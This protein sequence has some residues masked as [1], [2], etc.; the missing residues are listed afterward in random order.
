MKTLYSILYITINTALDEKVSIGIL[1]S[2]GDKFI[3]KYSSEKLLAIKGLMDNDRYN[4]IKQYL[5]SL[6]EE[7]NSE[8]NHKDKNGIEFPFEGNKKYSEGYINYLANYSNNIIQFSPAKSINIV[9]GTD[10]Y[11]KL[12]ERYIFSYP[13]EIYQPTDL[14]V[15]KLVKVDLFPKIEKRVNLNF[16]V[17]SDDFE[18]L[19]APIEVDFIGINGIPVA[20]QTIDFEK[21]HYFLE[22][23]VTRF[24]SL[25]KAIELDVKDAGKY[26]ILGREPQ[27]TSDKN[28][29]LW[30][31]I[32]DSDFL[33]F[34]DVED[35]ETVHKYIVDHNV[36]PFFK[37]S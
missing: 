8:T 16:T 12:F 21:K 7:F 31:Q 29:Q 34:V 6:E 13:E 11:K 23:D 20:G 3:Y 30:E 25:T 35:I 1:M 33:E 32:R 10:N 36:T 5:R 14:D 18:N 2:D 19:F 28:H 22:N 17:T 37:E 4:F 15:H 27:K 24:V 26:Y 9:F